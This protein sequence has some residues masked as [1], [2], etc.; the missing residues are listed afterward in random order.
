MRGLR[1][2]RRC[3]GAATVSVCRHHNC[4]PSVKIGIFWRRRGQPVYVSVAHTKHG[5]DQ[6][7]I[8]N[9]K[10]RRAQ[11]ASPFDI[12][13]ATYLPPICT[14]PAMESNAFS[15]GDTSAAS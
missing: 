13:G 5:R 10:I 7:S 1:G 11:S 2:F 8:V 12:P 15:F 6:D 3:Q 14:F 4:A 9:F